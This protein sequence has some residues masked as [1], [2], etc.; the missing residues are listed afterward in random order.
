MIKAIALIRTSTDRQEIESQKEQVLQ[1]CYYDGLTDDEIIND[2]MG[3]FQQYYPNTIKIDYDNAHTR[4]MEQVD[5]SHIT[6]DKSF[7]ELFSDF[8]HMIYGCDIS[9]EE[10]SIMNEVAREVGVIDETN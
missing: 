6:G 5:I 8:Y 10:M 2:A 9:E 1:M 4:E 3:I 7:F